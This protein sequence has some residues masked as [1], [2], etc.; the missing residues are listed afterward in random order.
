MRPHTHTIPKALMHVAGQPII[1]HILDELERLQIYDLVLIVGYRAEKLVEYMERKRPE[2][3]VRFVEQAE[4][5]G[6]GQAVTLSEHIV[7][8]QPALIVYGDT[9][10][11]GDLENALDDAVDGRIGTCEVADPSRF[12]VV[13]VDGERIVR[14]VEKPAEFVSNLAIVGV[15]YIRNTPLLYECL[16]DL[17]AMGRTTRGEYQLTD[18]F[19]MMLERGAVMEPFAVDCWHDCGTSEALLET[20]RQ[21]LSRCSNTT[22]RPGCIVVPPVWIATSAVVKNAVV[23]PY[24]S[25]AE[26]ADVEVSVIRDSIIGEKARVVSCLLEHSLVGNESLVQGASQRLN[27]GDSSEISLGV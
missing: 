1:G 12:G 19:Q 4:L 21:L 26:E 10:F 5:R 18:A 13:Q 14:M 17:M 9:V 6:L 16:R 7:K 27:V 15:N 11:E 22:E 2:F 8:D 25:I 20:N 3:R 24:V 23:G